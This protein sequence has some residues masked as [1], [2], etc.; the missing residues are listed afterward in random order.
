[1]VL[2]V[3]EKKKKKEKEFNKRKSIIDILNYRL[4]SEGMKGWI[5]LRQTKWNLTK[6]KVLLIF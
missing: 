1:M 3:K 2:S 6:E 5:R 4:C